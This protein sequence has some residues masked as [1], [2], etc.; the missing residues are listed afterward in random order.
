LT[1]LDS[2]PEKAI[3]YVHTHPQIGETRVCRVNP[4]DSSEGYVEIEYKNS[5][6]SL[7]DRDTV[8]NHGLDFG[9]MIDSEAIAFYDS[10]AIHGAYTR[11]GF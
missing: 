2:A 6:V 7:E 5:H 10:T 3:G 8:A 11:C 4:K 1:N 9:I